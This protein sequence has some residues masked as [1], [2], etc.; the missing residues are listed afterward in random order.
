MPLRPTARAVR[1]RESCSPAGAQCASRA[2]DLKAQSSGIFWCYD[3]LNS[4][5]IVK[6]E[7]PAIL[8]EIVN[9]E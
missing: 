9:F 7:V 1:Q 2:H 4:A 8:G 6:L 5:Y 3:F